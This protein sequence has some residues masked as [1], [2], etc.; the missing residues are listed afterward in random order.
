M[1]L[2]A[3]GAAWAFWRWAE[4]RRWAYAVTYVLSAGLAAWLHPLAG[5]FVLA[6][7]VF[8][9][10]ERLLRRG[11]PAEKGPSALILLAGILR[12]TSETRRVIHKNL[13]LS[14]QS[15]TP[16]RQSDKSVKNDSSRLHAQI[17]RYKHCF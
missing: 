1:T 12:L 8:V 7:F 15:S 3:F 17:V 10:G 9:G 5:A 16:R 11:R 6:P 13:S 14:C 4:T 2:C